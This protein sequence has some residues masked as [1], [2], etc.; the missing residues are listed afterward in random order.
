MELTFFL[1]GGTLLAAATVFV[2][3]ARPH[4]SAALAGQTT[5]VGLAD[6]AAETL[7]GTAH[8]HQ[9]RIRTEWHLATVTD[10]SDAEDLLDQLENYGYVERELIVLGNSTFTVRWR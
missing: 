8:D 6:A 7:P 9:S 10:L 1:I 5:A 3:V 2:M 4:E